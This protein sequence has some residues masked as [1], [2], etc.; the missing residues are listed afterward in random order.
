MIIHAQEPL[1][2]F[3]G[4]DSAQP[5]AYMTC[6]QSMIEHGCDPSIIHPV[7]QKSLR[8]F[9]VY[10]RPAD[11]KASTEFSLTRFLVPF[12]SGYSGQS[13]FCDSD[14]L[15]RSNPMDLFGRLRNGESVSVVK[16]DIQRHQ[17]SAVKMNGKEQEWY[18]MKNWSSLMLFENALCKNLTPSYVNTVAPWMLHRFQWTDKKYIG[19]LPSTYNSLVGYEGYDHENPRAVHF[20]DGGPWLPG[21]ENVP[22]AEEW[23]SVQQRAE[24]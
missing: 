5:E 13:L 6:R 10:W 15:W 11:E 24:R 20:T 19:W 3:I 23:R 18:P 7:L 22:F 9:G 12:L 8:T 1:A 4:F 21:Y 17:I 16:H 14:F 2:I